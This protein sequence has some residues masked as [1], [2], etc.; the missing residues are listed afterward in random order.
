MS[1]PPPRPDGSIVPNAVGANPSAT[2]AAL[3]EMVAHSITGI[4]RTA[5]L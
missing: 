3:S 2:I 5:D 4:M 1:D